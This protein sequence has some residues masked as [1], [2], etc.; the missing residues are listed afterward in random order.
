MNLEFLPSVVLDIRD[1]Q[2]S[3]LVSIQQGQHWA[4]CTRTVVLSFAGTC[5]LFPSHFLGFHFGP[6]V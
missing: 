1:S 4:P 5:G 3:I 6:P 2:L